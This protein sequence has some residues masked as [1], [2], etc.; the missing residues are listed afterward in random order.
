MAAGTIDRIFSLSI[1]R[2]SRLGNNSSKR[3]LMTLL[4]GSCTTSSATGLLALLSSIGALVLFPA[5]SIA[6]GSLLI[7]SC[8]LA[9]EG[10]DKARGG[11]AVTINSPLLREP[12][13]VVNTPVQQTENENKLG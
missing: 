2:D 8:R 9:V 12:L 3:K 1:S 4:T 7:F 13:A 6:R 5:S 10:D 11:K